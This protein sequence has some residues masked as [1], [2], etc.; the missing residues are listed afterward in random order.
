MGAHDPHAGLLIHFN[1]RKHIMPSIKDRL[2]NARASKEFTE[3]R[4]LLVGVQA[5]LEALRTKHNALLA[6]LDIDAGVTDTNYAA[7]LTVGTLNTQP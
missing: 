6:K 2:G 1:E 7:L 5:D 3:L 4:N